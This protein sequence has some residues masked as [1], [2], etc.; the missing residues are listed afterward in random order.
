MKFDFT[1]LPE[2]LDIV[3]IAFASLAVFE[4]ILLVILLCLS[5]IGLLRKSNR[6]AVPAAIV[7][8]PVTPKPV[9]EQPAEPT[10]TRREPA[11]TITL[12]EATPDAALQLLGLLQQEARFVDFIEEDIQSFSDADIGAAARIVHEGCHKVLHNHFEIA[13]VHKQR[14]NSRVTI[15]AGFDPSS[16]RLSGN[17]VG[18]PPFKGTLVH[19]GWKIT[20]TRLPKLSE[21]HNVSVVASAEV[22]L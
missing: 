10:P 15:Q 22:E 19:R 14:E 6:A 3:H 2:T 7:P 11:K 9:A 20:D 12:R 1:T 5:V 18:K 4:L 17:I 21:N 13:P 8:E 16:I